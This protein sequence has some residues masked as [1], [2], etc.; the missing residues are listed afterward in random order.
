MYKERYRTGGENA[1][2]DSEMKILLTDTLNRL[3]EP[4][5]QKRVEIEQDPEKV[6]DALIL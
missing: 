2:S 3:L 4:I 1:P 6:R 5:R